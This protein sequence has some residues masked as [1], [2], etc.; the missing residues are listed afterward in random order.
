M[1][2]LHGFFFQTS[3]FVYSLPDT[4]SLQVEV[5]VLA[6]VDSLSENEKHKVL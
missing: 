1:H 5:S 4:E 2:V 6:V 3:P